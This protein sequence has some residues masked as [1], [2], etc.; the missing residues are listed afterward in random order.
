MTDLF[1]YIRT[2]P[3]PG[4]GVLLGAGQNKNTA[5]M[6]YFIMGR[7]E[8]SRNRV[9][10]KEGDDVTIFPYDAAK[11]A[12]PSLIIYSPVRTVRNTVIVTNGDQTDTIRQFH[13]HGET[14]EAALATRRFEPDAPNFTPRVSGEIQMGETDFCYS[15]SIL[16]AGDEGGTVCK[17]QYFHYEPLVETGHI[18]HTYQGDGTPL[19]SFAGEP[20]E[21]KLKGSIDAFTQALW[22]ALNPQNKVALYVRYLNTVTGAYEARFVNKNERNA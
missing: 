19:P 5:V 17:R 2:N 18:I 9:F 22:Q 20:V 11:V 12:D 8:N 1:Q 10:V 14:F 21:V 16:K 4:R 7:S 3:Y 13:L 15:L 6:A